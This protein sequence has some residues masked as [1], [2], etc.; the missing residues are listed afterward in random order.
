MNNK[1]SDL[2][3]FYKKNLDHLN[4]VYLTFKDKNISDYLHNIQNSI[5]KRIFTIRRFRDYIY[6]IYYYP[7]K[8]YEMANKSIDR[9]ALGNKVGLVLSGGGARGISHLGVL[10][11]LEKYD[12]K[13]AF[14]IGTSVGSVVGA[15]YSAGVFAD[16]ML[17]IYIKEKE[18]F[19]KLSHYKYFT[20]KKKTE[21]LRA[22]LKKYLPVKNL[23]DTKIPFFIN[24]TD[25]KHCERIIFSTGSLVDLILASSAI[26]FLFEPIT[27]GDYILVDGGVNDNFCV[28]IARII[29][30]NNFSNELK[31]IISD[32]SAATDI[33]SSITTSNFLLNLSKEFTETI[34]LIGWE[35]YPVRDKKDA[36][37]II[38]NLLFL[39]KK[40]G[41]LAPDVIENE[42]IITP[43][44]EKMSVFDFKK[45]IWAYEK[46][47]ETAKMVLK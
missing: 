42:F 46:G 18:M 10:K 19:S 36:L 7:D 5:E 6:D 8:N 26:P 38:N 28:D 44:L 23:E 37:S 9:R 40:R 3:K 43:L 27:Y 45:Y 13:P 39:L 11:I 47:V 33:T 21:V 20:Q 24:A 4:S 16:E 1:S 41:G 35:K 17:E 25:V 31:I 22:I 15:M 29:N 2:K 30:K 34:K 14:I 12:I 32:V